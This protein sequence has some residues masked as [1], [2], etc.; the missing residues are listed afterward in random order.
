M[1]ALVNDT[2]GAPA[3][4]KPHTPA[5][6][7]S[8]LGWLASHHDGATGRAAQQLIN[9]NTGSRSPKV[10]GL[11][12]PGDPSLLQ[13][14]QL[15]LVPEWPHED[16]SAPQRAGKLGFEE[17][18]LFI[19]SSF[20]ILHGSIRFLYSSPRLSGGSLL[21]PGNVLTG[22]MARMED[23]WLACGCLHRV[24]GTTSKPGTE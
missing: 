11:W 8:P 5:S 7:F 23:G 9:A 15:A 19:L 2:R 1:E 10:M 6:H 12:N 4:C 17:F 16:H 14:F 18:S 3:S 13:V 21:G 22:W 20:A 24:S